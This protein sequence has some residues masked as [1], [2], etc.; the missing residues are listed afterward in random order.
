MGHG[1]DHD[2]P[3]RILDRYHCLGNN[4]K[5]KHV[6]LQLLDK[7]EFRH[8]LRTDYQD[9]KPKNNHC[10]GDGLRTATSR[11]SSTDKVSYMNLEHQ[12]NAPGPQENDCPIRNGICQLGIE[13]LHLVTGRSPWKSMTTDDPSFQTYL[14]SPTTYLPTILPISLEVNKILV[15]MLEVDYRHQMPLHE[16]RQAIQ[17]VTTFYS[18]GVIFEGNIACCPSDSGTDVDAD[19]SKRVTPLFDGSQM[20][21]E[22]DQSPSILADTVTAGAGA[23][24][25]EI[26]KIIMDKERR[27]LI[28]ELQGDEAQC[29]V[30][31]LNAVCRSFLHPIL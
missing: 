3:T 22:T 21:S 12:S 25:S 10:S 6:F 18:D 30:D 11:N 7:V 29:V 31:A 4:Q 23:C 26:R 13:L 27:R 5:I 17:D 1:P 2:P 24:A 16:V 19:P 14:R 15:G 9:P 20:S 28:L 8:P